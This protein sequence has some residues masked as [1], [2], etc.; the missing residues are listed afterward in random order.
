[1]ARQSTKAGNAKGRTKGKQSRNATRSSGGPQAGRRVASQRGQ[2]GAGERP[3][4]GRGGEAADRPRK[5]RVEQAGF[6]EDER[7]S[8]RWNDRERGDR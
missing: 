5:P 7:G 2:S 3:R 6:N 4:A 1:M 8:Y